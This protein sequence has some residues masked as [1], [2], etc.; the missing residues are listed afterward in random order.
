MF[1]VGCKL[2][3]H[4]CQ[5]LFK[6]EQF[7]LCLRVCSAGLISLANQLL[8][9]LLELEA[10]ATQFIAVVAQGNVLLSQLV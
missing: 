2:G 1:F 6:I 3:L 8:I 5:F 9:G 7:G 10:G 4:V